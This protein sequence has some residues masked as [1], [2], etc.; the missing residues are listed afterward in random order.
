MNYELLIFDADHTLIDFDADE[1]RA[2]RAAFTAAGKR[3]QAE[4]IEDIWRFS[5]EN[6]LH[7]HL[8]ETHRPEIQTQFHA[9]YHEHV[10]HIMAY[11]DGKFHLGER[12]ALARRAFEE[13]LALP[14]HFI[15]AADELLCALSQTHRVC[16][17][18]NGMTE[19]QH[20]RLATVKSYLSGLFISE[21]MGLVKPNPAFFEYI[22]EK[23]G[24]AREKCLMVGDSLATDIAGAN[25]A[26]IDCVW[27][28]RRKQ[29][30]PEGYCVN[31]VISHLAEIKN[32][33]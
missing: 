2:L 14:A 17:A 19:M 23:T 30:L 21:E 31:G 27:F 18:T 24:V 22:L 8:H 7:L 15:E 16:I 11:M 6:W 9:L 28:N 12:L 29:P 13:T 26:G 32:F 33:L 10:R 5:A 3:Y 25:G 20:G 1:R 4:D